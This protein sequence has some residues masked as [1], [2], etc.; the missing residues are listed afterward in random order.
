MEGIKKKKKIT[1]SSWTTVVAGLTCLE[2]HIFLHGGRIMEG[3]CP[4]SY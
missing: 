2:V 3:I 1:S 4:G